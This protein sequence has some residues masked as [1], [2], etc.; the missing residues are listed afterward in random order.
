MSQLAYS[1]R[2]IVRKQA[3]PVIPIHVGK[4]VESTKQH[5]NG[6]KESAKHDIP[7]FYNRPIF[8]A[9]KHDPL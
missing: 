6:S 4:K 7:L 1:R 3:A 5:E 8:K 9:K 2:T